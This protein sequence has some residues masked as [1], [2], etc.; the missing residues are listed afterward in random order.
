MVKGGGKRN[1]TADLTNPL[2]EIKAS[3]DTEKY[4]QTYLTRVKQSSD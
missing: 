2:L 1:G 3:E 4:R